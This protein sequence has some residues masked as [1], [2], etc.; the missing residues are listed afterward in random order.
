[1]PFRP[2]VDTVRPLARAVGVARTTNAFRLT[3]P[4][5]IH[6]L[7]RIRRTDSTPRWPAMHPRRPCTGV[8][9]THHTLALFRVPRVIDKV[10]RV[11]PIRLRRTSPVAD[12]S[13]RHAAQSPRARARRR[14]P[15]ADMSALPHACAVRS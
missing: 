6:A 2:Q 9:V 14:A 5:M 1:Q 4:V 7:Q 11:W 15:S 3:D 10:V 13:D 8:E 12:K